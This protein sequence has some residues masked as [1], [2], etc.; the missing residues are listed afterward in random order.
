MDDE[1][2]ALGADAPRATHIRFTANDADSASAPAPMDHDRPRFRD[3]RG[4]ARSG[5][6][7]RARRGDR[8]GR[9][10]RGVV[11]RHASPE[12]AARRGVFSRRWHPLPTPPHQEPPPSRLPSPPRRRRAATRTAS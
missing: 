11:F 2:P 9:G 6:R 8:G 1:W 10:G 5:A 12:E 4:G 7:A 3:A